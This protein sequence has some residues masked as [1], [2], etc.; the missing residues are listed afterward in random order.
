MAA[1]IDVDLEID[2]ISRSVGSVCSIKYSYTLVCDEAEVR[3]GLGFT[4]WCE[5]WGQDV[6][7]DDVL[8]QLV[9]DTHTLAAAPRSMHTRSFIVPC[10]IL[11]EDLGMDEVY[12][13]VCA[14]SSL[15]V[16]CC[17]ASSIVRDHF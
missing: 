9:Y 2:R 7:V 12:A 6:F 17:G 1:V 14:T 11:D 16:T 3:L 8:G 13:K 5:L 4:L 15:G 10:S